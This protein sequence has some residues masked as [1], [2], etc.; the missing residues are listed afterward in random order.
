MKLPAYESMLSNGCL[1]ATSKLLGQFA[2]HVALNPFMHHVEN[3]PAY[4]KNLAVLT[5]QD[6]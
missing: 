3:G 1:K 6:F 2:E 4:F 5:L